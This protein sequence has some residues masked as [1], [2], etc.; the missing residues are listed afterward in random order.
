[1]ELLEMMNND[2]KKGEILMQNETVNNIFLNSKTY[3]QEIIECVKVPE[4]KRKKF[5]GKSLASIFPT[6]FCDAG[7]AHCFFKSGKKIKKIPQEQYEF[8]DCGIDKFIE[9]INKSNNGYLLVI[10]GGE[11]FKK[12][13]QILKIVQ[14]VKT[15]RLILVTNGMW[16]KN[17]E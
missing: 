9:F 13:R 17:Y 8:S 11:P 2:N 7:C 10:G 14:E 12:F 16:A 3:I 1:M 4:E 15:D 5:E 6:K